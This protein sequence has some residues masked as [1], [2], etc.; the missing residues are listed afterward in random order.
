MPRHAIRGHLDLS[1]PKTRSDAANACL[2]Q[3]AGDGTVDGAV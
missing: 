1:R 3:F 2:D